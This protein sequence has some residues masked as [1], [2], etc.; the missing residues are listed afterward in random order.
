MDEAESMME[1]QPDSA[2]TILSR[3]DKVKL[4][5]KEEKARYALLMS[6]ALD[7][8][9]IDTTTFDVLQPA[10]DYYID[11]GTPDE[12]LRTYYYQGRIFQNKGDRDNAISTFA[13]ALDNT[14]GIIDSLYI[15]RTLVAQA[16]LYYDFYDFE[17]YVS[18]HLRAAKIYKHY[19]DD[20]YEFDCLLNALNGA[21]LL[22]NKSL[23]DSVLN[24]CNAFDEL[25][26]IQ[27]NSL[28]NYKLLYTAKHGSNKDLAEILNKQISGTNNDPGLRLNLALAYHRVGDNEKAK[29]Y[30]DSVYK[31]GV[32]FDTLK[33]LAI[34]VTVL[35]DLKDFEGAFS[36]YWDYSQKEDAINSTRFEQKSKS[37]EEKHELELKAREA[38]RQRSKIL[39]GSI[40]GIII[41]VLVIGI[42]LLLFRSNRNQKDLALQR[43][44]TSE[45]ENK[46]LKSEKDLA[47]QK[48]KVTDLENEKLKTEG[49]KLTL[50]KNQLALENRN[51]QLEMDKKALEAEN[52]AHRVE[53]LENESESLKNLMVQPSEEIPV[54]VQTAIKVRI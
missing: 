37:I 3:I 46:Q 5:S 14:H 18:S 43:A 48:A 53:T 2:M 50:E 15:A 34:S 33:Y 11:N 26:K 51:L 35:R 9:Y 54:E 39:W 44:K 32:K 41:L 12:K 45:L 20:Y 4:S 21:N 7:K 10:I 22:N 16:A 6:V 30:L 8:N 24:L 29:H 13:K 31:S 38:E 40:C 42:L 1:L 36:N 25:D 28:N 49:E 27:Q 17:S 47:I 19:S 52:L 23:A